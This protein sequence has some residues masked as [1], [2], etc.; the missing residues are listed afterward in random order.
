MEFPITLSLYNSCLFCLLHND[1]RVST[2]KKKERITILILLHFSILHGEIVFVFFFTWFFLSV[3]LSLIEKYIS[4]FY[5]EI[6][7]FCIKWKKK[8][9]QF[10]LNVVA[11]QFLLN[12]LM[13]KGE[14]QV[15]RWINR[16][17]IDIIPS[18]RFFH[19]GIWVIFF[20]YE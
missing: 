15:C 4:F 3:L 1:H 12:R 10:P 18:K 8:N 14:Q 7:Q 6:Y 13:K 17:I 16:S 11:C 5:N 19:C 20:F 9:S 2:T